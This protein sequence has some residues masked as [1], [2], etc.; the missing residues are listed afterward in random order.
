LWIEEKNLDKE[1]LKYYSINADNR[2]WRNALLTEKVK[3]LVG[4][5]SVVLKI[6]KDFT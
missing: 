3:V 5:N 6:L 2:L 1:V 4:K